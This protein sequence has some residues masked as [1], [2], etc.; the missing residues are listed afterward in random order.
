LKSLWNTCRV[1]PTRKTF[2][3]DFHCLGAIVGILFF[4]TSTDASAQGGPIV[5][6][7]P[8]NEGFEAGPAWT[9]GGTNS[10]WAWGTPAHPIV[11]SAGGGTKS[12]CIGGLMGSFY[13]YSE[14]SWLQGPCFNFSTLNYPWISFKIWWEDEWKYD[15]LVLQS[16]IDGGVTWVNVGKF[17]D[18][19]DCL[20]ANWYTYNNINWLTSAN[21]K[22]GWTG[23][24]GPTAGP[25]QGGNGS[26][27]WVTAK[28]CL[29]SLANQPNVQL[30]FL[31]GS[32]TTCNGFDGMAL[33]D[34]LIQDAPPNL[35]NFSSVCS[36]NTFTFTNL[37]APC[38]TG[39]AWDF[40]E[41]A[42]GAANTSTVLNPSHT[43]AG[44]GTYTVTLV[45][46]GPCNAPG[47]I[48][49]PLTILSVTASSTNIGCGGGNTGT[50]TASVSGGTGPYTYSWN[51]SGQTT[52]TATGLGAGTYT[53]TASAPNMCPVTATTTITTQAGGVFTFNPASTSPSCSGGNNGTAS[54]SPTGGKAPYSYNWTPAGVTG[55]GTSTI[56]GLPAG[57]YSCSVKDSLGCTS[58]TSVV[59]TQPSAVKVTPMAS[60]TICL[61]QSTPLTATGGGGTPGYTYT[62]GTGMTPVNPPVSPMATTTYSVVATD[63]NGCVSNLQTVLINVRPPLEV[64]ATGP[65]KLCAGSSAVIGC[66]GGGGTGTY[67]YSWSPAAGLSNT[68]I[69]NPTANPTS[70]TTYTVILSDNCTSPL[71]TTTITVTVEPPPKP[72]LTAN[73]LKGCMP[74]CVTFKDSVSPPCITAIWNFGDGQFSHICG[75]VKHC[76]NKAGTFSVSASVTDSTGCS[77]TVTNTKY[78]TVFPIPVASFLGSPQ[79][80]SIFDP[81]VN[82]ANLSTG[83]QTWSWTFGDTSNNTS[84]L[85][86]PQHVY[87]DTGCYTVRLIVVSANGC[88]DT[89]KGP[90]CV[91]QDFEFYA[92]NTFTPNGDLNNDEFLPKGTGISPDHYSLTIFDRWGNLI[93]STSLLTQGWNGHANGGASIAQVDTYV[94]KVSLHDFK[95]K[96]HSY[97]GHV[98]LIR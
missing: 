72:I 38:P 14:L 23:R 5:S 74:L 52:Q 65:A 79:P 49:I 20:N 62:W 98:N 36:G 32:G 18:P 92:P 34:I 12:W 50:A 28:H 59:V 68:T 17:G 31:F 81:T 35:P 22:E 10:D 2:V 88:T 86:N 13:N 6:T 63:A 77:G 91:E 21:P 54:I 90:I 97:I 40:G 69:Q 25:C 53:V 33:D 67:S 42:S 37:S 80:V 75:P 9:V 19:V 51:P 76:Y 61:G 73:I 60:L 66:T 64:T 57:T 26:L 24:T 7:F 27:T 29:A 94:W 46:S 87:P 95:G 4:L 58:T 89:S 8:Y 55:Q 48:K 78:I 43:Y 84:T 3:W 70:T 45:S 56:S 39:Y 30:R 85:Q 96:S 11:N 71:D 15:G 47:T 41:P 82:F 44:P 93:F 1:I 83:A 16:S